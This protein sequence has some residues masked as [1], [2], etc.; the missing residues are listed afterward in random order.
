MLLIEL[1]NYFKKFIDNQ[2]AKNLSQNS[3]IT[4]SRIFDTFYDYLSGQ[5]QDESN[6]SLLDVNNSVLAGYLIELHNEGLSD[7]TRKLHVTVLKQLFWFIADTEPDKYGALRSKVT[8]IKVKTVDREVE[9]F[10]EDEQAKIISLIN[11]LDESKNFR[12]QRLSLILK[13]LMFHGVRIDELINL[14]WENVEEIHDDVAGYVYKFWYMGKGSKERDLDFP[15]AFVEKNFDAIKKHIDSE[16]VIPGSTGKRS[17]RNSIYSSVRELLSKQGIQNV[18]LHK[19]R[20]TF[21]QNKVNEGVN[22]TTITELMG[23]ASPIV[24][25][26]FYLRNN[27]KAKR[28]AILQ[29][30]PELKKAKK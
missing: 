6:Q 13:L 14:K 16:F 4:Y 12:D 30:L 11:S 23:H 26:K 29:G 5:M 9:S 15:M 27:K 21:G 10:N 20:H 3:I 2:K 18:Y 19:F 28:N 1:Q 8:G 25:Y 7:T 22:S 17:F 24:T